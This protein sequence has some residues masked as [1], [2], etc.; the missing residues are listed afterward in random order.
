EFLAGQW[1]DWFNSIRFGTH[2]AFES[3]GPPKQMHFHV[4][5]GALRCQQAMKLIDARDDFATKV[6]KHVAP[7]EARARRRADRLDAGYQHGMERFAIEDARDTT[8]ERDGLAGKAE[9]A[10]FDPSLAHQLRGHVDGGIDSDGEADA[11]G[12]TSHRRVD[13]DY[14]PARID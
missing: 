4:G 1:S 14:C 8:V 11:L 2:G 9:S 12:A 13:A 6:E 7:L 3:L 5:V 10:S